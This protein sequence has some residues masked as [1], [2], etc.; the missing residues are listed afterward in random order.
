MKRFLILTIVMASMLFMASAIALATP[1]ASIVYTETALGGGLWQYDYT[2]NNTSTTES[3]F[4]LYFY[5]DPSA[6][7][8]WKN[9]PSGWD[10]ALN[11]FTPFNTSFAD[12]YSTGFAHDIAAG[13]S[14]GGFR[15]TVDYQA[16]NISYDA[17]LSGDNVVSGNTV[18]TVVPEPVSSILFLTGGAA[19]GLRSYVRRKRQAV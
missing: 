4:S 3:L 15:F 11:G 5:F 2:F 9:I 10:S 17:Y 1:N 12:T 14:L 13:N 18:A 16:G 7:F 19:L 8:D 6:T